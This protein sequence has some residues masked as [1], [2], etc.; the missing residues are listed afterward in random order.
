MNASR[1]VGAEKCLRFSDALAGMKHR[2]LLSGP[3]TLALAGRT[4]RSSFRPITGRECGIESPASHH[5]QNS[6]SLGANETTTSENE[7]LRWGRWSAPLML[8]LAQAT[9]VVERC[10]PTNL[11]RWILSTRDGENAPCRHVTVLAK[12]SAVDAVQLSSGK[13]GNSGFLTIVLSSRSGPSTRVCAGQ[14]CKPPTD[15]F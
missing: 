3:A 6:Y 2:L 9:V 5:G 1:T 7:R 14:V 10:E 4:S 12:E 15:T 8:F 13:H 11:D